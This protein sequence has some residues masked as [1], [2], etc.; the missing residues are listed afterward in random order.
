MSIH[1]KCNRVTQTIES[2]K[3]QLSSLTSEYYLDLKEAGKLLD[4]F[5]AE[6]KSAKNTYTTKRTYQPTSPSIQA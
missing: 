1:D 4:K 5:E 3:R 2:L 6:V